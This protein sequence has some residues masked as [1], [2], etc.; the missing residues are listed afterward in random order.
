MS[1]FPR[2]IR[3]VVSAFAVLGL[4]MFPAAGALL[5]LGAALGAIERMHQPHNPAASPT[6]EVIGTYRVDPTTMAAG[7]HLREV[8][9]VNSKK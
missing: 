9:V 4:A 5:Q 7:V 6:R 2:K 8:A 3:S 1:G